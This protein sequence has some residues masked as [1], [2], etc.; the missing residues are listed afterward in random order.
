[1]EKL[2]PAV[3]KAYGVVDG[4]INDA[5]IIQRFV[6][7]NDLEYKDIDRVMNVNLYGTIHMTKAFPPLSFE[8]T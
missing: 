6:R 4:L 2:P 1:M 8:T 5:G 7:V 3:L